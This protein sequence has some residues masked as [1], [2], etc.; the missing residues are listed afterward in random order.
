MCPQT[1]T[2]HDG[3]DWHIEFEWLGF[4]DYMQT[5]GVGWPTLGGCKEQKNYLRAQLS[6]DCNR[7]MHSLG[8]HPSNALGHIARCTWV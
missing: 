6:V 1:C 2:L 7:G 8:A 5:D 3:K 4:L